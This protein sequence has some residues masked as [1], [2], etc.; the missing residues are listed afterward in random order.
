M[1][2]IAIYARVSDD[3]L[4]EDGS[5]RQ[6]VNRQIEKLRAWLSQSP[7]KDEPVEL[8]VDD[9]K[10]AFREDFNSRPAFLRLH[11][12]IHTMKIKRVIVEDLTRWSRRLE[13]GL[14]TMRQASDCGCTV[15]SLGEGEVEITTLMAEWAAR[16]QSW[17]VKSGMA[18]A[19]AQGKHVGRP[20]KGR[21][22]KGEVKPEQVENPTLS[23]RQVQG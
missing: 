19:K 17:K 9:G 16:S 22:G 20:R 6:D 1:T 5:R 21:A 8:Y 3:K 10:S 7:W 11:R 23:P 4:T 14:K 15:T 2:H 12:D 18:R 13:E